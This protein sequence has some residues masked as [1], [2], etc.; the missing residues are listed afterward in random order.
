MEKDENE[1]RSKVENWL[2]KTEFIEDLINT[3]FKKA[4]RN[5]DID[6]KRTIEL[7]LELERVRLELEFKDHLSDNTK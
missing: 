3:I 1:I 7:L 6:I 2:G 5:K 4:K